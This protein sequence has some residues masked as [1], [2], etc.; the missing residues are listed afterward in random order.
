MILA[1]VS[2]A[3]SIA[4]YLFTDIEGFIADYIIRYG[5]AC[6]SSPDGLAPLCYFAIYYFGGAIW[7]GMYYGMILAALVSAITGLV[8]TYQAIKSNAKWWHVITVYGV[9]NAILIFSV[10][11]IT[12]EL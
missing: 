12:L 7:Y 5:G 6:Y 1:V 10:A 4:T 2:I 11:F 8:A 9:L 3:L